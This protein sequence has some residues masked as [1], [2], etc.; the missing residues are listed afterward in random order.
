M[1][2]GVLSGEGIGPEVITCALD[3]LR[4][5]KDSGNHR[6]DI[7]HG[8]V[9][10]RDAEKMH[11]LSLS[12]E[13]TAFCRDIFDAGGAILNGPGGGRYVYDLRKRFDLYFKISPL[14]VCPELAG[15]NRL[16]AEAVEG[17]NILLVR[18]NVGGIY[19]GSSRE[20]FN[21]TGERYIE[22]SF[23]DSEPMVRRFLEAAARL[24]LQRRGNL[25]VV[26]KDSGVPGISALWRQ[27]ANEIAEV[28][29]VSCQM[30][31][32]DHMAY[33][34]IQH[35]Q[36]LDVIAAPNMCG[37]V[38]ADLG[39][40]LLGSRGVSFSGNYSPDGAAVYQTNH[41]AAY[42]LAGTDRAN[43]VG[44][45]FSLAMALRESF[46][47]SEEADWIEQATHSVWADGWRTED[48]AESGCRIIS[49]REMG[50]RI[51]GRL[52]EVIQMKQSAA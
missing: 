6:F 4:V 13:A 19:Q 49:T 28:T 37:D 10:G 40:A 38:L 31:D 21:E 11:G 5:L 18:D 20:G 39:A 41:G 52:E 1:V 43:P 34:L 16:K 42:D 22:H 2:L 23:Q 15:A 46:N 9:I 33:R 25:V 17:T 29:G 50:R 51:A 7:R 3:L 12:D 36:D 48:I 35:A 32:I 14:V 8:G 44:Q 27:C 47:L 24:S 45:I 30:V 26:C